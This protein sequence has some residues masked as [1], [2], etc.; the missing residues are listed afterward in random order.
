V[1][2]LRLERKLSVSKIF[3]SA[4]ARDERS[5]CDR[6]RTLWGI[7]PARPIGELG[8]SSNVELAPSLWD[9]K[10]ENTETSEKVISR[11]CTKFTA[12]NMAPRYAMIL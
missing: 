12:P 2:L 11:S 9:V 10:R 1:K 5:P 8:I 6:G 3:A 4:V 7:F